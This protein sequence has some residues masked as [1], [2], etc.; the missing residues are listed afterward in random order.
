MRKR[1]ATVMQRKT[2]LGLGALCLLGGSLFAT[3]NKDWNCEKNIYLNGVHFWADGPASYFQLLGAEDAAS[4]NCA[5]HLF[6]PPVKG[7]SQFGVTL[8]RM[9][10]NALAIVFSYR[11]PNG[12]APRTAELR[13]I[14]S[15]W[16]RVRSFKAGFTMKPATEWT[17]MVLPLVSFRN[18][19][20]ESL[21]K[22][23]E[24]N[25]CLLLF[26]FHSKAPFDV[27]LDDFCWQ[28]ADGSTVPV[29]DF[30]KFNADKWKPDYLWTWA[31]KASDHPT[32]ALLGNAEAGEGRQSLKV[33]FYGCRDFQGISFFRPRTLEEGMTAFSFRYRSIEG[34][35]PS[36]VILVR[37]DDD[38]Q[39]QFICRDLAWQKDGQW[40][41]MT[42]PLESFVNRQSTIRP[43]DSLSVD[44]NGSAGIKGTFAVDDLKFVAA[45][46]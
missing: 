38:G 6:V 14:N 30:E 39:K 31:D 12:T 37:K 26:D 21:R 2:T 19:V 44:F 42:L 8:T 29:C 36:G 41:T 35:L 23:P 13:E 5:L 20:P 32:V 43:G 17:Q 10:E 27:Q 18:L 46:K 33:T 7:Y 28:L 4:G 40:H 3:E 11:A 24:G 16:K 15:Q 45:G 22:L 34:D 25:N 1:K 9:P